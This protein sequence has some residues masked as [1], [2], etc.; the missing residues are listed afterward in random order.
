M[1]KS[2]MG[3]DEFETQLELMLGGPFT[4]DQKE[5]LKKMEEPTIASIYLFAVELRVRHPYLSY[6]PLTP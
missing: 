3:W 4:S 5:L 1:P 2:V 6:P